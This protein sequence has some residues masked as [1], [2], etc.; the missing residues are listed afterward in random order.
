MRPPAHTQNFRPMRPS[1]TLPPPLC[2]ESS[3]PVD[4]A[5]QAHVAA[6]EEQ[7]RPH[8]HSRAACPRTDRRSPYAHSRAARPRTDRRSPSAQLV[9]LSGK[10][11]EQRDAV[12]RWAVQRLEEGQA[13]VL[14][15]LLALGNASDDDLV[16][17][18]GEERA[19]ALTTEVALLN[20]QRQLWEET[21]QRMGTSATSVQQALDDATRAQQQVA[22]AKSLPATSIDAAIASA[23][24]ENAAA[25]APSR[26]RRNVQLQMMPPT[27]RACV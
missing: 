11:R 15:Q 21:Q 10:V 18:G 9:S 5:L 22:A 7:V 1:P 16:A 13:S 4:E 14:G 26:W 12:P 20:E 19:A 8:T 27:K 23:G 25:K 6:L 24:K 17:A 2:A 3:A